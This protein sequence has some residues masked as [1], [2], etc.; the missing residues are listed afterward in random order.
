MTTLVM[1][2]LLS[3]PEMYE[4]VARDYDY[5]KRV[6][7][8]ALRYHSTTSTQRVLLT[9]MEYRGVVLEKNAIVWFPMSIAVHDERYISDPDRFDPERKP[10]TAHIAFG[11]G[12][13][14]CLGQYLARAL[15]HEGIHIIAQRLGN[16]ASPGPKGWRPFPGAWGIR[17][18]PVTFEARAA[19][20]PVAA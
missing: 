12:P 19:L 3:R 9:D 4:R 6:V 17:G 11:L 5:A 14:I 20:E 18:L 16:P 13:H 1:N 7:D 10:E 15:I 8:E 2:L